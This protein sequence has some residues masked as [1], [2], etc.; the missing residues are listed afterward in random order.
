LAERD[1]G[2][3]VKTCRTKIT[4]ATKIGLYPPTTRGQSAATVWARKVAGKLRPRLSLPRP[5]WSLTAVTKGF[6]A[7][8]RR[9][10]TDAVDVLLLH[11]PVQSEIHSEVLLAWLQGERDK[12]TI[13]AWGLAG[14]ANS[15]GP[16]LLDKNGLG[17]VLQVGDSI[18]RRE[19]DVVT[20]SGRDLQLTYGYMASSART[21]KSVPAAAVLELALQRNESGS[22]LVSTRHVARLGQLAKVVESREACA[23]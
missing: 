7:S 15:M 14:Q 13:R 18:E 3:L 8:L 16:W 20:S 4:L 10:R 23:R 17:M 22:I 5:D 12:G 11:D 6:E 9:L 21:G 19:A 1:L 2:Q